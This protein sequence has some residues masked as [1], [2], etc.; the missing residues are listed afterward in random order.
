MRWIKGRQG[1]GYDKLKLFEIGFKNV[2]GMDAYILRYKTGDSIPP[3]TDPVTGK[4]HFRLNYELKKAHKG[5]V[6]E[7]ESPILKI[8]RLCIFRSDA[9]MHSVSKIEKGLR[10][11]LT[12]GLAIKEK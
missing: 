4:K 3:H 10:L 8:G 5:G 7:V 12:I 1:T 9:S 6:L 2:C 11:V